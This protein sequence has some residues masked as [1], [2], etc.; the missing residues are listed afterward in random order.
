[1]TTQKVRQSNFEL[2]RIVS[3]LMIVALHYFN[4][5][6]GGALNHLDQSHFNFY[7]TYFFESFSMVGVN[8]F[9]LIMGYFNANKLSVDLKSVTILLLQVV[10]YSVMF[11]GVG[12]ITG[13]TTLSISDGMSALLPFFVG[14]KWFVETYIIMYLLSP[15]VNRALENLNKN[16]FQKLLIILFILFSVWPS[17]LP[18]PPVTDGGYGIINFMFV[19]IIG[20]YLRKHYDAKHTGIRYFIGYLISGTVTF[21]ASLV[22]SE[23]LGGGLWIVWGYNFIFCIVGSVF[24]FLAFS[25]L[26]LQS[27]LINVLAKF[28]FGV[29]L[30][31]ADPSIRTLLYRDI[32][33]THKFWFSEFFF[34][35]FIVTT[36]LLYVICAMIDALRLWIFEKLSP[37]T[38]IFAKRY[39]PVILK[40]IP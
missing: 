35:H 1:M 10:F 17:M 29:Y 40:Q 31:H 22:A 8:C 9:I 5:S 32:L 39:M 30:I 18:S 34:V 28:A 26:N 16:Q 37:L 20:C 24:L 36:I 11:Y 21:V 14:V 38:S 33:Q 13:S 25:K 2:L 27:K 3:M 7:V 19:Y 23:I 6:I 15:F 4:G 12:L